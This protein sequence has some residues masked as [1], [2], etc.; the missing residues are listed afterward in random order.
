MKRLVLRKCFFAMVVALL[1]CLVSCQTQP[2]S[3][4]QPSNHVSP[5]QTPVKPTPGTH[6]QLIAEQAP[7]DGTDTLYFSIS[8]VGLQD[9][10]IC[11]ASSDSVHLDQG[12]HGQ[13]LL[14]G[15]D[16][17]SRSSI[18]QHYLAVLSEGMIRVLDLS[19]TDIQ[20]FY[21]G[22]LEVC[23]IDGDRDVEILLQQA[24]GLVGGAGNY[25]SRVFDYRNGTIIERFSSDTFFQEHGQDLGFSI[26]LLKD[27][28]FTICNE[29][30]D[31]NETF[32]LT[33]RD[34]DY[35]KWWC[36]EE[37]EISNRTMMVDSFYV[38]S[39]MDTDWDGVY[40]IACKQYASLVG[41]ADGI[42]AVRT[43][44]RYN[45][46]LGKFEIVQGDFEVYG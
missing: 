6:Q 17:K 8:E 44:L 14:L 23:D 36:N 20:Y 46:E 9:V 39:P 31:Y 25:L 10:Y 18:A 43:L 13:V 28:Q 35:F 5:T 30:L 19:M 40:E 22:S 38:F 34:E 42:G 1:V 4:I 41:H 15:D 16:G 7:F 3:P 29:R 11:D 21:G 45:T 12:I 27:Q 24:V 32:T 33:N 37:G 2:S 26:T